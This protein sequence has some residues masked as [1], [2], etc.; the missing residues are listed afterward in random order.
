MP[1]D[2]RDA[3]EATHQAIIKG[4]LNPFA[5]PIVDQQ[6]KEVLGAGQVLANDQIHAMNWFVEGVE[7][8]VPG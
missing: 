5:G 1:A 8:E 6:G 7:G 3:A 4:E 2:V